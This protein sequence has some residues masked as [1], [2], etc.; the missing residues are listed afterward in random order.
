MGL[1]FD[2]DVESDFRITYINRDCK[3][4]E[5]REEST[6]GRPRINRLVLP[7]IKK[8]VLRAWKFCKS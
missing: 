4:F 3:T 5:K 8:H 7:V 6:K 1:P 2:K